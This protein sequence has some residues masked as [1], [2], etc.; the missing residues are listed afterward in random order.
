MNKLFKNRFV[1]GVICLSLA[2]VIGFVLVPLVNNLTKSTVEVV[3]AKTDVAM[4]TQL[5]EDMLEMVEVGKLNLPQDTATD[6]KQVVGLYAEVDLRTGDIILASKVKDKLVLP[7]NKIRQMKQGEASYT[8]KIGSSYLRGLYPNDIVTFDTFDNDGNVVH[9]PELQYVSVI[10]TTTA[11]GIDILQHGQVNKDGSPLIPDTVT[12]ILNKEQID[13]LLYLEKN[14]GFKISL[15]YR[16][17]DMNRINELLDMQNK[18]LE[19]KRNPKN[20]K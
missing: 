6:M 17:E 1:I 15:R 14:S 4:G 7:E 13:K 12:F 3:R 10:T 2:V 19:D 11:E 5:T 16:G 20:H 9:V 18:I 8:V